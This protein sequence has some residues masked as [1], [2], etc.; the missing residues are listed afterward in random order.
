MAKDWNGN[1]TSTYTTLGASNHTE[2][3][4]AEH[5]YYST[6]PKAAELLLQ[7]EPALSDLV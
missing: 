6:E 1:Q 2:A 3:D 5:D 4:R 7:I